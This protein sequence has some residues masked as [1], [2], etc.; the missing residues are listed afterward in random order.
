MCRPRRACGSL[1]SRPWSHL[2]HPITCVSSGPAAGLPR[3]ARSPGEAGLTRQTPWR[4]AVESLRAPPMRSPG[5]ARP[6][7][8]RRDVRWPPHPPCLRFPR[9]GVSRTAGAD[10]RSP[11]GSPSKKPVS[12]YADPPVFGLNRPLSGPPDDPHRNQS[13]GGN[14]GILHDCRDDKTRYPRVGV[15][16][17]N[18][19]RDRRGLLH[20]QARLPHRGGWRLPAKPRDDDEVTVRCD[21]GRLK[22]APTARA[23]EEGVAAFGQ[24]GPALARR[25]RVHHEDGAGR[26]LSRR[27]RGLARGGKTPC[28]CAIMRAAS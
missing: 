28:W 18:H 17:E 25:E 4:V 27:A 23:A 24:V 12:G 22:A 19:N 7:T 14:D 2:T 8:R 5:L 11:E 15:L 16:F 9:D 6:L 20:D 13:Q 1:L 21:Q 26:A 3:S 10:V